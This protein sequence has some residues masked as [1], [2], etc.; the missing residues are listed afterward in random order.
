[1]FF[2]QTQ[3]IKNALLYLQTNSV[4]PL[5][6]RTLFFQQLI[7]AIFGSSS[8]RQLFAH[9]KFGSGFPKMTALMV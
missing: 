4:Q 5:T 8:E 2:T 6:K 1:M 3:T 9:K 7:M